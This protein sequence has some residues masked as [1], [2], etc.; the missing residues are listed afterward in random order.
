MS[1]ALSMLKKVLNDEDELNLLLSALDGE[2]RK[3]FIEMLTY[4]PPA[5]YH[6]ENDTVEVGDS[7][8]A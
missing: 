5:I 1:D 3:M 2:K 7:D 6:V 8:D 4:L